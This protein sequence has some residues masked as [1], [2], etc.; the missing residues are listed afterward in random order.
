MIKKRKILF[1]FLFLL[2]LWGD[3]FIISRYDPVCWNKQ[4]YG[5]GK[6]GKQTENTPEVKFGWERVG[7]NFK[8]FSVFWQKS[9]TNSYH[10]LKEFLVLDGNSIWNNLFHFSFFIGFTLILLFYFDFSLLNTFL[11][12][13][14]LS[15]FHEYVAEGICVNPSFVDLWIDLLGI[16]FGILIFVLLKSFLWSKQN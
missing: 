6:I 10:N 15:I 11:I 12:G 7:Y 2:V 4:G 16:F 3:F 9:L 13:N 8:N 5:F 1:I 14:F